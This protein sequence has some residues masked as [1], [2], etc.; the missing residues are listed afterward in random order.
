MMAMDFT[1]T[2]KNSKDPK[3]LHYIHPDLIEAKKTNT[4]NTK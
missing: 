2:N 1:L 4:I 3:S